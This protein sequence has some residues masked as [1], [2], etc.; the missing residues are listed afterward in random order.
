[1]QRSNTNEFVLLDA[2]FS[3]WGYKFKIIHSKSAQ[4][5][6]ALLQCICAALAFSA[7]VV[8]TK[9]STIYNP[10][11]DSG[12]CISNKHTKTWPN[13]ATHSGRNPSPAQGLLQLWVMPWGATCLRVQVCRWQDYSHS[14][15]GHRLKCL[16][17][18]KLKKNDT[19]TPD[20]NHFS[21]QNQ[22]VRVDVERGVGA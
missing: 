17:S 19:D 5:L 21:G 3:C 8:E 9:S 6:E 18:D 2:G 15:P 12:L 11:A 20:I 10:R 7:T 1:M 16:L 4:G 13:P 14:R 22:I